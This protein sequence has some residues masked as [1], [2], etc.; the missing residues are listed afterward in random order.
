MPRNYNKQKIANTMAKI[1]SAEASGAVIDDELGY[2]QGDAASTVVQDVDTAPPMPLSTI[3][4]FDG[5]RVIKKAGGLFVVGAGVSYFISKGN[6]KTMF[7][8]MSKTMAMGMGF[9][10]A[11]VAQ[12]LLNY[13]LEYVPLEETMGFEAA[14]SVE[15]GALAA[16]I[17]YLFNLSPSDAM[18]IAT[19]ALS[20][21]AG[22]YV[23]KWTNDYV[24]DWMDSEVKTAL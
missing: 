3:P 1:A 2:S 15:I 23:L 17:S 19:T 8:N 5:W 9:A 20:A 10:L 18:G 21:G 7:G 16:L 6:V 12:D 4:D 24:I 22:Y 14:M 13:Y 11:S